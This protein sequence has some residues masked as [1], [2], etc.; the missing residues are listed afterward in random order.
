MLT[1]PNCVCVVC[2]CER[3]CI[4]M[5][6]CECVC[7]SV[8]QCWYN[9][10]SLLQLVAA[11]CSLLQLIA[12]CCSLLLCCSLLQLVAACCSLLQFVAACCNLLHRVAQTYVETDMCVR[13]YTYISL[14]TLQHT[15]KYCNLTQ[16]THMHLARRLSMNSGLLFEFE[17]YI[18]AYTHICTHERTHL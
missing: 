9:C 15:A 11:C 1:P 14:H 6:V 8:L 5:C 4:D 17:R 16:L 13:M 10:C 12:A 3:E 18:W 2:V 7:L